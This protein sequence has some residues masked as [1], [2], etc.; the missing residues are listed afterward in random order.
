MSADI[1]SF[2]KLQVDFLTGGRRI[3]AIQKVDLSV[4]EGEV[5]GLVGESGCGKSVTCLAAMKLLG[6]TGFAR[7]SIRYRGREILELGPGE[8]RKVRG[9]EIAMIFQD[10]VVSLDPVRRIGSQ[11]FEVL[12]LHAGLGGRQA[13][14]R[15]VELLDHVGIADP[16]SRLRDYPH[17]LSGGLCQRVMIAIA[18]AGD[19]NVLIADEPTTAL[20]V[21]VQAQILD[22]LRRLNR[23]R[24]MATVLI[25][26]DLG[27]VAENVRR[28]YVM[29]AGLVVEEAPVDLLFSRPAHPYTLGLLNSLP[30][31]DGQNRPL[32][33]I[34][35]VVPAPDRR[36]PGCC[37]RPRCP[38]A[39]DACLQEQP[40][41]EEIAPG[42]RIACL[43]PV[44]GGL[45]AAADT[46]RVS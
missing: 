38:Y 24:G 44:V 45:S 7:G 6:E 5:I 12:K 41:L 19:P 39:T 8:M 10:P 18:L 1:L 21:T 26:H 31:M 28:V 13:R 34:E 46:G 30:K 14:N 36:P 29:Y 3:N 4:G 9:K 15:A 33:P 25:T 22:L 16:E 11:I 37:F 27:V 20:D 42:H 32:I 23:E 2:E 35:G 40:P 43:H 17:Q